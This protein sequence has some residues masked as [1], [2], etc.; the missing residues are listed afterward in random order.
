MFDLPLKDPILIVALLLVLIGMVPFLARQLRLPSIVLLILVGMGAG[1]HGLGLIARDAQLILLE[2]IGLLYIMLLAGVQID[3]GN[4]RRLG[5]RS[6]IFGVL[7]F[8]VPFGLGIVLGYFGFGLSMTG[9]CVVGLLL[10]PHVLLAYPTVIRQGL[11]QEEFI[12]V[13]VGATVVTSFL[14][15]LVFS[16]IQAAAL[17][18]L[19]PGFTL[20]IVLGLPVLIGLS[21]WIIP[22]WGDQ[23]LKDPQGDLRSQFI[24][25]LATLFVV[26]G[27]TTLLGIDA[28]VGAFIAGLA[29]NPAIPLH[30]PLMQRVEFVG[31]SLFIP[32]F[33]ISVGVL[34]NPRVLG[35]SVEVVGITLALTLVSFLGKAIATGIVRHLFGYSVLQGM[36]MLSLTIA[37]AALVLVIALF[38]RNYELISEVIFNVTVAYILLTCLVGSALTEWTTV[39]LR[40]EASA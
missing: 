10:S 1:T 9:A 35:S 32:S 26:A 28:I 7:T 3:L 39:K 6:L 14:T 25:V 19:G 4:L 24:F 33:L 40:S 27:M 34:C 13:T 12:G 18:T 11:T 30:S 17:G 23:L 22:R 8:L 38:A 21:F 5:L 20:K 36:A 16:M 31:N 2:K 15:L 37:R 29:L